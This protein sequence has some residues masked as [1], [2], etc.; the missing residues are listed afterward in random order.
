MAGPDPRTPC[1]VGW[2]QET[3]RDG[4]PEPLDQWETVARAAGRGALLDAVDDLAVV[5]T[6]SW[7]YDDATARLGERLG[8]SPGR[9]HY[10]GIGGSTPQVLVNEAAERVLAGQSDVALICGAEA[11]ATRRR[12]KKAGEKPQWSHPDPNRPAFPFPDP[13]HP[14][15]MAH[16]VWEAWLTFAML[17]VARRGGRGV[18]PDEYRRV[19]GELLSAM[20]TVAEAN[21][22][23]WFPRRRTVDELITPTADNRM[24]GYPYT[25][26]M[27][28]VM[29]V[30]MAAALV[31]SSHERADAL[32][33]P[34]DRRVYLRGWGYAEDTPYLAERQALGAS[35]AMRAAWAECGA[36]IDDVA[37]IDLY[38][39]FAGSVNFALDVL[40][41]AQ[42]D[43]RAPF[44][45]TGG[46][47]FSGGAG[48][49]YMTHS[50][51]AMADTLVAD[52]GSL[53]LVSGVGMHMQKHVFATYSTAPPL[54]APVTPRPG[55][56]RVAAARH[57]AEAY[58]GPATIAAYSVV[59]GR[60]GAPEWG[61]AICDLPD[62]RRCYAR[63]DEGLTDAETEEWVGRAVA[64]RCV[65]DVN[66]LTSW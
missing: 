54:S 28:S 26:F 25:K 63:F 31:L 10:S 57:I 49:D 20:S 22:Y 61:V 38:S 39:C 55:V 15:E 64:V 27:I 13:F 52:P 8:L 50:V 5:Y 36:A 58:E 30:D 9:R 66:H 18:A 48:S 62:D 47:P 12:L 65:G 35:A 56:P 34:G 6:Q 2:A 24:V 45:V 51:A 60:D 23:A 14:A 17:D 46:L 4:A 40:G 21:P 33:I 3:W 16:Q 11:L 37:H 59:H 32:G 19:E 41:L 43:P 44:T 53:G 29:D 42:D 1:L 7:Q